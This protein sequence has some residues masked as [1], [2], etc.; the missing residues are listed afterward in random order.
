MDSSEK[1]APDTPPSV[2]I[3]SN[4]QRVVDGEKDTSYQLKR[5]EQISL[6]KLDPTLKFL[7]I[8]IG[9]DVIGFDNEAPDLDASLFLLDKNGKTIEDSDFVFYNNL[10]NA[11]GSVIHDGDNRTGAGDGDD[12]TVSIDLLA[13]PFDIR[14]VVFVIS[15]YD[16]ALRRHTL[17]NVRNCFLR[18]VNKETNIELM[19]FSLDKEFEEVPQATAVKVGTLHRE[20]PNWLFEAT[21]VLEP[22]GLPRIATDY[23]IVVAF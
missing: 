11:D 8:G 6:T 4:A 12:E 16:A 7:R 2:R 3:I 1:P 13:L 23:G 21:G 14:Q 22:E 15:I 19:R 18:I 20:G 10:K 5:G 9:W 17:K